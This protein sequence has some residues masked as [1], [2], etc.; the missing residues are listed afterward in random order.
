[1]NILTPRSRMLAISAFLY[2]AARCAGMG[3]NRNQRAHGKGAARARPPYRGICQHPAG[4]QGRSVAD[5]QAER[6]AIHGTSLSNRANCEPRTFVNAL[7]WRYRRLL[8]STDPSRNFQVTIRSPWNHQRRRENPNSTDYD[9]GRLQP[10]AINLGLGSI[11]ATLCIQRLVSQS[12]RF[13]KFQFRL[14]TALEKPSC[15]RHGLSAQFGQAATLSAA[16]QDCARRTFIDD[17]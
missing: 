17:R 15:P 10:R 6:A 5:D 2:C 1:M 16:G 3:T 9:L 14:L 13:F 7:R 11:G 8:L 4:L 12:S